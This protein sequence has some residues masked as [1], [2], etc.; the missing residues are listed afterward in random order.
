MI[1]FSPEVFIF[2][3]PFQPQ[4]LQNRSF[5]ISYKYFY[6][7]YFLGF[8]IFMILTGNF[9]LKILSSSILDN[10]YFDF[11]DFNLSEFQQLELCC[12]YDYDYLSVN[13]SVSK[14][15]RKFKQMKSNKPK[16]ILLTCIG[17]PVYPTNLK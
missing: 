11:R 17:W 6:C 1:Y 3:M 15:I 12:F 9:T 7:I 4:L 14:Y 8:S 2:A 13:L 10:K 16:E 5:Y